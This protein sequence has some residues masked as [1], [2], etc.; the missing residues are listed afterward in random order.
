MP[1]GLGEQRQSIAGAA[2]KEVPAPGEDTPAG[3]GA[4]ASVYMMSMNLNKVRSALVDIFS[5]CLCVKKGGDWK[6]VH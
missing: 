1:D 3:G 4:M 2:A 6:E 5:S